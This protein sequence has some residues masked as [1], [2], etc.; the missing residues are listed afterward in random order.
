MITNRR[1]LLKNA[2]AS[3]I[4]LSALSGI[5]PLFADGA[6]P[7][8][9][10]PRFIFIRKGNGLF[11]RVL[12]PPTLSE[13]DKKREDEMAAF[14]AD[15]SKHDL[16]DWLMPLNEHKKHMTLLQGLSAKMCTMGHSTFQ[17]PLGVCRAADRPTTITRATVDIEL[18]RMFTSPFEH[19][20]LTC[21]GNKKGIVNG[22]SA[23][24]PKQ[25][26]YAFASPSV[27]FE[28]LFSVAL[29]QKDI[30][31][32]RQ[33]DHRMYNDMSKNIKSH[34]TGL[35]D[36][37]GAQKLGNYAGSVDSIIKRNNALKSMAGNIKKHIPQ[38]KNNVMQDQYNTVE[39]QEAFADILLG[40]LYAGLTNVATFTVDDLGTVYDGLLE[41]EIRLHHVGHN[42]SVDGLSSFDV[43]T[44]LRTHHM[45]LVNRLVQGLKNMPEGNGSM[46]DNTIIMY[47]PENGEAHHSKGSEVPFV[48]MAGDKV[49]LRNIGGRYIRLPKYNQPGHKTLGNFYTTI[50]NAYGNPI[51]HYGDLDVSL[52]IDQTGPIQQLMV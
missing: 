25:P 40:A 21:A 9:E 11:P 47:L 23:L 24:G 26:N 2:T 3:A 16:P 46:F 34:A 52:T 38:I 19:V 17:S 33:L 10:T 35:N 49:K 7:V 42:G 14:E 48:I 29:D 37:E 5:S 30:V 27:A 20:E 43:R 6:K 41:S 1:T 28:S 22:M 12:V 51:K 15:L 44:K 32:G 31:I 36:I 4:G 39:Q 8:K 50:L 45:N 13:S 18:G